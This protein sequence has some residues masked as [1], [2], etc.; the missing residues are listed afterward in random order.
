[1]VNLVCK[2]CFY[3]WNPNCITSETICPQ[4]KTKNNY[5]MND[6]K[7]NHKATKKTIPFLS[8]PK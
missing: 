7:L 4:C 6:D 1:M 2:T 5:E 3:A 8:L